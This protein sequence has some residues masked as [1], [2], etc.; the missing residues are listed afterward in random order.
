MRACYDQVTVIDLNWY[1]GN[2]D[3]FVDASRR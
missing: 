2:A 1:R 3:G